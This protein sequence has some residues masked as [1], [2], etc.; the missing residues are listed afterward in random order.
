MTERSATTGTEAGPTGRRGVTRPQAWYLLFGFL[1]QLGLWIAMSTLPWYA[2]QSA[3]GIRA[4]AVV[5]SFQFLPGLVLAP[6]AGA[7]ADRLRPTTM[8]R[9]TTAT[10]TASIG[11]AGVLCLGSSWGHVLGIAVL[12][13][14]MT[15]TS[16]VVFSAIQVLLGSLVADQ[17]RTRLMGL[18]GMNG[19]LCRVLGPAA[20]ASLI[21]LGGA[22]TALAAGAVSA[23]LAA[24]AVVPL[25]KIERFDASRPRGRLLDGARYVR[26]RPELAHDLLVFTVVSLIVLNFSTLVPLAVD[27]W[28]ENDPRVLGAANAALGVGALAGGLLLATA[29]AHAATGRTV[30]TATLGTAA[31]LV[32]PTGRSFP[33]LLAVLVLLGAARLVYT[34]VVQVRVVTATPAEHRGKVAALYAM[35]ANGTT[36]IGSVLT[37]AVVAWGG[38]AAGFGLAGIVSLAATPARRT[39]TGD[40]G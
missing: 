16:V 32:I 35:A 9:W 1:S 24:L 26:S 19:S 40:R 14:L 8:L 5:Q 28:Y 4:L 18:A 12:A 34:T 10:S 37:A 38:L 29:K 23:A 17:D 33:A 31:L 13:A 22:S 25:R 27:A 39:R 11:G 20:S 36:S 2:L 6:V 15:A 3:G 7:W 30:A 21:V